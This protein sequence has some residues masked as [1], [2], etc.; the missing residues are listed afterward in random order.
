MTVTERWRL[1]KLREETNKE[2]KKTKQADRRT[3]NVQ[4][5]RRLLGQGYM[6]CDGRG[7]GAL[8]I[9]YGFGNGNVGQ[10]LF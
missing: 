7:G 8:R 5:V 4:M 9:L 6:F 2:K 1:K 3:E 10:I